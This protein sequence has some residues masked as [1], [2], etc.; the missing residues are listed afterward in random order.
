MPASVPK[1]MVL[2]AVEPPTAASWAVQES[3]THR[4]APLASRTLIAVSQDHRDAMRA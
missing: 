4:D 2:G 1:D 3:R